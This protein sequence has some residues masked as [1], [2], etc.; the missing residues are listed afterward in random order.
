MFNLID[1]PTYAY[2]YRVYFLVHINCDAP[3]PDAQ[4]CVQRNVWSVKSFAA[5]HARLQRLLMVASTLVMRFFFHP[6]L[7]TN[8]VMPGQMHL[9][10]I[11]AA[12]RVVVDL[13]TAE[14]TKN[15]EVHLSRGPALPSM[16]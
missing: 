15:S 7:I 4:L 11:P 12:T 6:I 10:L 2:R 1:F 5:C 3:D 9:S 13:L 8:H 16:R 14:S